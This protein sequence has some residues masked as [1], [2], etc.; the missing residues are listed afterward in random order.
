[1]YLEHDISYIFY[2][3]KS[4]VT[5]LCDKPLERSGKSLSFLWSR[6]ERIR[7]QIDTERSKRYNVLPVFRYKESCTGRDKF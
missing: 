7:R 4:N 6:L 1:M 3:W 5:L 2:N